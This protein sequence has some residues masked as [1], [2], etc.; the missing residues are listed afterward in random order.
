MGKL[1]IAI[2]GCG[3]ISQLNVPG[4]LDHPQCDVVA[5]CDPVPGRA[6]ARAKSWEIA[7]KIYTDYSDLLNDGQ[8]D[9]VELLTPTYMHVDQIIDGLNSGKHVSC[10]KPVYVRIRGGGGACK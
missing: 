1:N 10:Q 6:A 5:L 3:S 4:Y 7:P 2:V 8:V 9:A